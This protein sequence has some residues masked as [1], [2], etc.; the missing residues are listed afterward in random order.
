MKLLFHIVLWLL[1][2]VRWENKS[3][4]EAT[5]ESAGQRLVSDLPLPWYCKLPL[6]T[7]LLIDRADHTIE[8]ALAALGA[9]FPMVQAAIDASEKIFDFVELVLLAVENASTTGRAEAV[10]KLQ[11]LISASPLPD[12]VKIHFATETVLND[13]IDAASMAIPGSPPIAEA[14]PVESPIEAAP[15]ANT[16]EST[17]PP[18]DVPAEA[19]TPT[20]A[21]TESAPP[22]PYQPEDQNNL[23]VQTPI[24]DVNIG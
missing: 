19:P 18:A 12:W 24:T 11:S 4:T 14:A 22:N 17:S 2:L 8:S 3:G 1:A 23:A 15:P 13:L 7:V 5:A 10:N 9:R 20:E 16:E 6:V 21:P